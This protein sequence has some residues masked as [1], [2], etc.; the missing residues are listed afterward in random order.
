MN[1]ASA[2]PV[3][4]DVKLMNAT[5]S[6]LFTACACAGLAAVAWWALRHPSFALNGITVHGDTAHNNAVTLRANVTPRLSG[7]FFTVDLTAARA[8]FESV[9]W[10]RHAVVR[11]EFPNRLG[12]T[13][14]E[15]R[16]VA[17]WGAEDESRMVN[18]FGEVFEANVDD[19]GNDDLPRL[20]GPT[21]QA[22]EV[23]AMYRALEPLFGSIDLSI[24]SLALSGRGSW[25]STLDSGAEIELGRGTVEEVTTRTRQFARTLTQVTSRYGR[26]T[27]TLEA[28]DLRHA[29]GYAVRI[30]GITTVTPEA[31]KK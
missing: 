17:L 4:F 21:G 28:A 29:Q 22:A 30:R 16:P 26:R 8:A 19:A 5:A 14:E 6:V 2:I 7:N 23:L 15:H 3:P 11:R 25:S 13:L 12:V 31:Q 1:S 9:P 10:V 24:E 18:T 27:D 20:S